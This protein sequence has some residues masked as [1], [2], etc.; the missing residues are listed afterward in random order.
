MSLCRAY[1]KASVIARGAYGQVR[2][3]LPMLGHQRCVMKMFNETNSPE[4]D[5]IREYNRHQ[6]AYEKM[7]KKCKRHMTRPV[8]VNGKITV[9]THAASRSTERVDTLQRFTDK[10]HSNTNVMNA[11]GKEVTSA[12]DCV[13]ALGESGL[14]H[15]NL[16]GGNILV[17]YTSP[18]KPKI[19][20]IDW[21]G[22]GASNNKTMAAFVQKRIR[23][24]RKNKSRSR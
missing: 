18:D 20:I 14:S 2:G 22:G 6:A 10:F 24:K 8:Y 7:S 4:G 21:G 3:P 11:L 13:L 15:G 19:K 1:N 17:V 16:H 9:Q 12:L 5:P 23:A